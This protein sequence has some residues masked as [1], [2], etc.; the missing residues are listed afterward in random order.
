MAVAGTP[1]TTACNVSTAGSANT[2]SFAACVSNHGAHDMVGNL[3][4]W[5]AD[6]DEEAGGCGSWPEGFGGDMTCVGRGSGEASTRFPGAV[7]RGGNFTS[8]AAAGPFAVSAVHQPSGSTPL[9]GF[10]G[11]R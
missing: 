2:G 1:D 3:F 8:G 11:A 4:E 6:W 5:V 7:V 10:R 9:R